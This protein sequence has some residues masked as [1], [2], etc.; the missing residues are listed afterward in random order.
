M[1]FIVMYVVTL[2]I[3]VDDFD[4]RIT[5]QIDK[6]FNELFIKLK[7]EILNY[8][9]EQANKV[10]QNLPKAL[11]QVRN[12][13]ELISIKA[14]YKDVIQKIY[15]AE[16]K[17]I[18][19]QFALDFDAVKLFD[20]STQNDI[21]KNMSSKKIDADRQRI[22]EIHLLI[23]DIPTDLINKYVTN[24]LQ[25]DVKGIKEY[26][27]TYTNKDV[28]HAKICKVIDLLKDLNI[29]PYALNQIVNTDY[30]INAYYFEN[31]L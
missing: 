30:T 20:T 16:L 1:V 21:Y 5:K 6:Y 27:T 19:D 2:K 3:I 13:A 7:N 14:N 10:L 17:N 8:N 28:Q 9:R 22:F 23:N 4:K 15:L 26:F 29:S 24:T 12:K 18:C 11:Q 25:I 31:V